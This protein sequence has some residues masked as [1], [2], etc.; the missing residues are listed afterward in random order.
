MTWAV[1]NFVDR[2]HLL[3]A[4]PH[5]DA[6]NCGENCAQD[7]LG[8]VYHSLQPLVFLCV[9]KS[10]TSPWCIQPSYFLQCM[11]R[12]LWDHLVTCWISLTF[13][14]CKGSGSPSSGLMYVLGLEQAIQDVNVLEFEAATSLQHQTTN[15]NWHMVSLLPLSKINDW[16]L[17]C[18]WARGCCCAPTRQTASVQRT[19]DHLRGFCPGT[20]SFF[21]HHKD[22]SEY[23]EYFLH[24][25]FISYEGMSLL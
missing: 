11:H 13:S 21:L 12:S 17:F 22:A 10:C 7:G 18:C 24:F 1:E 19:F 20:L 14:E 16:F 2:C 5:V 3:E 15:E 25:S 9:W 6:L 8:W 4:A 23:A